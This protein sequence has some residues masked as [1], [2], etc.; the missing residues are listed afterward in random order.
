MVGPRGDAVEAGTPADATAASRGADQ[1]APGATATAGPAAALPNPAGDVSGGDVQGAPFAAA[2]PALQQTASASPSE[3][4]TAPADA[5]GSIAASV[6]APASHAQSTS[7]IATQPASA[8]S[9]PSPSAAQQILPAVVAMA[10]GRGVGQR[11]SVSITPDEMGQVSITVERGRNGTTIIQVA[12]ERLATLDILRRDQGELVRAL[13]QAGIG[14]DSSSLSFSWD[15]GNGGM[16][17]WGTPRDAPGE[18]PPAQAAKF[19]AEEAPAIPAARAAA[20]GGVD[21]TA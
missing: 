11:V 17:G 4:A 2:H 14:Q 7:S 21:V 12:A 9:A 13:D 18:Q 10:Q 15:G 8:G 19:Y 5:A 20:R 16:P 6:A 1:L 3:P